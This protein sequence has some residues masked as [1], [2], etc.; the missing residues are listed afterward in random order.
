[1]DDIELVVFDFN[2]T[3]VKENTWY[4]LNMAM[5][6]TPEEDQM[7]VKLFE[8]GK[9]TYSEWWSILEK[10]YR[11]RGNPTKDHILTI[12]SKYEYVAGAEEII[13]YLKSKGYHLGLITG[14]LDLLAEKVAKDLHIDLYAGH[15]QFVFDENHYLKR[16]ISHDSDY[17]FKIDTLWKFCNRLDIRI[18]QT[19]CIGDGDNDT[20]LFSESK[21]GVTFRG[22]RVEDRAWKVIDTLSDLKTFL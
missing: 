18:D 8:N 21:H 5:G 9:I 7:Y 6:V 4:E 11:E 19:V 13:A 15:S 10:I 3:L 14:S 1:M 12:I 16:I 17:Q 22:S 2:K 20:G